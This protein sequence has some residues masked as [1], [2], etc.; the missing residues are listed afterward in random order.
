MKKRQ[1]TY[2]HLLLRF[3]GAHEGRRGRLNPA[4]N[5]LGLGHVGCLELMVAF[6]QLKGVNLERRNYTS[7]YADADT[8]I[9]N[10]ICPEI[11][12]RDAPRFCL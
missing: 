5:Q 8:R 2:P 7:K 11:L 1:G 4:I 3:D 12:S 6:F 10:F 9:P